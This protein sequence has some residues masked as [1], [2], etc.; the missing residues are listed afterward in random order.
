MLWCVKDLAYLGRDRY[1]V[2]MITSEPTTIK[3]II[4]ESQQ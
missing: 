4:H 2:M 1:G 3:R